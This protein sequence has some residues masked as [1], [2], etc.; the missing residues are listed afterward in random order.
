MLTIFERFLVA[1]N[2]SVALVGM[3]LFLYVAFYIE[4]PYLA[5]VA[6]ARC[7]FAIDHATLRRA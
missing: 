6:S 7:L 4:S 5:L 3:M 2:I 1:F